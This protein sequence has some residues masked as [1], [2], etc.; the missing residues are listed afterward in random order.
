MRKLKSILSRKLFYPSYVG[1]ESYDEERYFQKVIGHLYDVY[2]K[3]FR[4]GVQWFEKEQQEPIVEEGHERY[5][6]SG[7]KCVRRLP[8]YVTKR[9]ED[10]KICSKSPYN[11]NN[12]TGTFFLCCKHGYFIASMLMQTR[13]SPM[14][15]AYILLSYFKTMPKSV[16]YDN[17]CNTSEFLANREPNFM[18]TGKLVVDRL[19][20]KNHKSCSRGYNSDLYPDLKGVNTQQC[21][22]R[23]SEMKKLS[24]MVSYCKPWS[25]WKIITI[26]MVTKNYIRFSEK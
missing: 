15:L 17:S 8:K 1:V 12:M 11:T 22:Q 18:K 26:Y 7:R 19:H 2:R 10:V 3:C 21:E 6:V 5:I 20:I 14:H 16:I 25:A 4:D 13:E 24:A 9:S 23:N